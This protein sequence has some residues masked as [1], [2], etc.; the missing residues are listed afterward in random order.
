MQGNKR[1]G[2]ANKKE[3]GFLKKKKKKK[4]TVVKIA[5]LEHI[6]LAVK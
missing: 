4:K 6:F 5:A 3:V 1:N 2:K